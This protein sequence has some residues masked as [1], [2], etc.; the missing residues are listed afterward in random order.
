[1][2]AAAIAALL[3][4]DQVVIPAAA[5]VLAAYGAHEAPIATDFT[6]PLFADTQAFNADLVDDVVAQLEQRAADFIDRFG[7]PDIDVRVS[8]F[9]DAR[10]P[11]QAWDLRVHLDERPLAGGGAAEQV[12][13]A[14]HAEHLYRNGIKDPHSRVEILNWGVRAE[15]GREGFHAPSL[16]STSTDLPPRDDKV[17]FA[18]RLEETPRYVGSSLRPGQSI[19]GPAIVDEAITT[20]VIPPHWVAELDGQRNFRLRRTQEAQ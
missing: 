15:V 8:Y 1:M 5:G 12:A 13:Q 9:V 3:E 4:A 11:A 2:V 19:I 20:V 6:Y 16:T 14:F 17:V 18:S 10:Y 7:S